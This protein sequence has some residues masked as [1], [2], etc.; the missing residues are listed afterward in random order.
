MLCVYIVSEKQMNERENG[1]KS[2]RLKLP[3]GRCEMS[4]EWRRAM[5][6]GGDFLSLAAALEVRD[7]PS[8]TLSN[9]CQERTT[10]RP[11]DRHDV[12]IIKNQS[13]SGGCGGVKHLLIVTPPKVKSK[14]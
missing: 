7:R 8:S 10:E 2:A 5:L 13:K 4:D 6:H 1:N 9:Q 3:R 11:A 12:M 14:V